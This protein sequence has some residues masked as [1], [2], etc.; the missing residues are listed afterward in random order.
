M[1]L[2]LD[3]DDEDDDSDDDYYSSVGNLDDSSSEDH[4]GETWEDSQNDFNQDQVE[5]EKWD[6]DDDNLSA[7]TRNVI[8]FEEMW[9]DADADTD[10][11]HNKLCCQLYLGRGNNDFIADFIPEEHGIEPRM[12]YIPSVLHAP[13]APRKILN[14]DSEDG[15]FT[16]DFPEGGSDQK[17]VRMPLVKT[18]GITPREIV[19]DFV[20]ERGQFDDVGEYDELGVNL[21]TL[22]IGAVEDV[23]LRNGNLLVEANER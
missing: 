21:E 23:T 22:T 13:P 20:V 4:E 5:E 16:D 19:K 17:M 10:A 2:Q 18:S 15:Q 9:A 7:Q 1:I 14:V 3:D 12:L 8:P 6:L 11:D